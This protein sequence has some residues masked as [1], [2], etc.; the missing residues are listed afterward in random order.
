MNLGLLVIS[1]HFSKVSILINTSLVPKA[2]SKRNALT[3][4]I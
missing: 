3:L 2:T 1:S 4:S